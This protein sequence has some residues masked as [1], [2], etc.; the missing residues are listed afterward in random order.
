M[1]SLTRRSVLTIA[2]GAAGA[3]SFG[4]SIQ[5]FAQGAQA[6]EGPAGETHGMSAFGDLKYPADFKHLDY[7]NP[8]APKGGTFSLV[9]TS[10]AYNQN[11]LTFNTMNSYILKGDAPMGMERTFAS[12]MAGASDEP[13]SMYGLAR[14][15]CRFRRMG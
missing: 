2:A 5:A 10:R 9:G 12:L 14:A 6:G 7:V 3:L 13:D 15:P 8:D 1:T 4:R 11:F